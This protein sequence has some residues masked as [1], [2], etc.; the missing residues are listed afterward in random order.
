MK[1]LSDYLSPYIR[2]GIGCE[3]L[4]SWFN[5]FSYPTAP[6]FR[7]AQNP[8]GGIVIWAMGV[9][10]MILI[11]DALM[12]DVTPDQVRIFGRSFPIRWKRVFAK[13][14]VVIMALAVCYAAHPYIA[15]RAGYQIFS[16]L[17]FY[18]RALFIAGM[19]IFDAKERMRSIG[20]QRAFS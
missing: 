9:I 19:A 2:I 7:I 11:V 18:E 13:R 16:A 14:H 17:Y 5:S 20:W 1:R 6:M 3:A 4:V 8:D 15:E 10:G 12:N